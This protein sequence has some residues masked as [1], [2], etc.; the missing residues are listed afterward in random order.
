MIPLED[1]LED[2]LVRLAGG[3]TVGECL[4]H[5]PEHAPQ[6]RRMLV[7][8]RHLEI[9]QDLHPSPVFVNRNRTKLMAFA[10]ANPRRKPFSLAGFLTDNLRL[11]TA[12]SVAAFGFVALGAG[13][14]QAAVPGDT[15]YPVKLISEQTWRAVAPDPLSVDL[16]LSERRVDELIKVAGQT[17]R[18][19]VARAEYDQSLVVL[20]SYNATQ[21]HQSIEPVLHAQQIELWQAS[22]LSVLSLNQWIV[23]LQVTVTAPAPQVTSVPNSSGPG[24]SPTASPSIGNTPTA[25]QGGGSIVGPFATDLPTIVETLVPT[26]PPL[27]ATAIP[28]VDTLVPAILP[29]DVPVVSPLLTAVP[30]VVATTVNILPLNQS[31]SATLQP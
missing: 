15:L 31:P 4:E 27:V 29:T 6:L 22:H 18:E 14:A 17:D 19:A 25:T 7:A 26:E 8:A 23:N 10:K 5:Y 24:V 28:A 9:G 20:Q 3:A 30:N 16:A 12:F 1:A 21:T 11:A 13:A 2:C